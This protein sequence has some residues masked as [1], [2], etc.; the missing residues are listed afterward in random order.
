MAGSL[1]SLQMTHV[2][3]FVLGAVGY[4]SKTKGKAPKQ[5]E[6]AEFAGI[7]PMMTSKVVRALAARGLLE[8]T[9]DPSD[10]RAWRV[11]V[12][13]K[14]EPILIRATSLA[15]AVDAA[16][17][18]TVGSRVAELAGELDELAND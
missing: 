1:K 7:D 12:T 10:S 13:A 15:R 5:R 4:L 11:K 16:F 6:V 8:R 2:Q 14:G 18:S 3:F 9:D 17:F